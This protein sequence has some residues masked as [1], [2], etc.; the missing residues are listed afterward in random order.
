MSERVVVDNRFMDSQRV[1]HLG[2]AVPADTPRSTIG[3]STGRFEGNALVITTDHFAAGTIEPRFG[4]MHTE[5]LKLTE[6]LEV[7]AD[8]ELAITFTIDDPAGRT[9]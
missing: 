6:R 1:V 2:G 3:Y 8:G 7:N 4:I 5:N 9:R